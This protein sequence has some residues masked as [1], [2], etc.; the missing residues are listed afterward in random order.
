MSAVH[1]HY[2]TAFFKLFKPYIEHLWYPTITL[3]G[4]ALIP[5][6]IVFSDK[7]VLIPGRREQHRTHVY[8]KRNARLK[9]SNLSTEQRESNAVLVDVRDG[10]RRQRFSVVEVG[11]RGEE[12]EV[13]AGRVAP[14]GPNLVHRIRNRLR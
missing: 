10:R 9:R 2:S 13:V 5:Q 11:K 1:S 4:I 14:D 7:T 6:I 12:V 8:R 3:T